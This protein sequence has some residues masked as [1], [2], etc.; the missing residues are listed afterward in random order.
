V[1][2]AAYLPVRIIA[3]VHQCAPFVFAFFSQD[4]DKL[5]V[6]ATIVLSTLLV[7]L[8]MGILIVGF[9]TGML[10]RTPKSLGGVELDSGGLFIQGQLKNN[11]DRKLIY[12]GTPLLFQYVHPRLVDL[13]LDTTSPELYRDRIAINQY[14]LELSCIY[15]ITHKWYSSSNTIHPWSS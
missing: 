13:I 11:P 10:I 4:Q 7:L 6:A 1:A 14:S 12:Y 15:R 3:P 5:A 8:V 2:F 9:D